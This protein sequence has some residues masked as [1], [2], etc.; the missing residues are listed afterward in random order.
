MRLPSREF[1]IVFLF[2][3]GLP[4]REFSRVF[5]FHVRLP[6]REFSAVVVVMWWCGE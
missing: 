5:L 4:S 1:S 2:H 6:S 3:V